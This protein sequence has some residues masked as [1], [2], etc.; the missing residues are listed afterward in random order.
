MKDRIKDI[1]DRENLSPSAF[2]DLLGIGRAVISH[3]LNGRNNPS[4]EVVTRILETF[5]DINSD[6]LLFGRGSMFVDSHN[7]TFPIPK[8]ESEYGDL[9][10]TVDK[11]SSEGKQ[12][13][14]NRLGETKEL[15]IPVENDDNI[16]KTVTSPINIDSLP[17]SKQI[18][19][20][21]IYYD[22]NSFQIFNPSNSS[23]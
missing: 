17:K 23:F 19:K 2:A 20:I 21:I 22:D 9:F 15:V 6:W 10:S 18:A 11:P 4:L 14:L 7:E 1:M 16:T 13:R 5:K 12:E 8:V 3:I